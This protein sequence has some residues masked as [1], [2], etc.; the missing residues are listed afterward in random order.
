VYDPKAHK[1]FPKDMAISANRP[2]AWTEGLDAFSFGIAQRKK[3]EDKKD[4]TPASKEP[5]KKEDKTEEKKGPSTGADAGKKPELIIWHWKDE[6]L[7][8]MQ[9]KQAA[10]DRQFSY[11]CVYKVKEKKFVRLA[12]DSLRQVTLAPKH[13]Y[14]IGRHTKSY[15]YMSYLTGKLHTDVYVIDLKTGAKKKAVGKL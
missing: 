10:A 11:A 3:K 2:V 7:Q 1:D 14:A 9:E 5:S 15:E 13:H 8:P 4:T 12:D 6:R